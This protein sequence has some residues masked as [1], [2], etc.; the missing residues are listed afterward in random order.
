MHVRALAVLALFGALLAPHAVASDLDVGGEVAAEVAIGSPTLITLSGASGKPALLLLDVSPGPTTV[1]G[2][3]VALGFTPFTTIVAQ[4]LTDLGGS[5]AIPAVVPDDPALAGATA[6]L[7]GVLLDDA[8]PNGKDFSNGASLTVTLPVGAGAT[9]S[10]LVDRP[11]VLDGSGSTNALGNLPT[12]T[13]LLWEMIA[14]PP[15]S[16]PSLQ[17]ASTLYPILTPDLPGDY[18]IR[19]TLTG[20]LA[21]YTAETTVHAFELSL[22][23]LADGS[24]VSGASTFV[25]GGISG[26]GLASAS[27]NGV[28]LALD[29]NGNFGPVSEALPAGGVHHGLLFEMVH[30]DGTLTRER[31]T[32]QQG[33]PGFLFLPSVETLSAQIEATDLDEIAVNAEAILATSDLEGVL[34]ALPPQ[35]VAN[36]EG[37][38]GIT[39]FSATIDFTG[40]SHG[41]IDL[42]M[43]PSAGGIIGNVTIQDVRA[44]FNVFGEIVEVDYNLDGYITTDPTVIS[45]TL[46]GSASG[47]QIDVAVTNIVVD[48]QNFDFELTGFV[49]TVAELFVI[50]DSVKQDVENTI[51]GFVADDLG[52][53]VEELLN[54]F[55]IAGNL[56]ETLDVDVDVAA[57]I[58]GVVHSNHG[59]SVRLNGQAG[60]GS[61]E[62][63]APFINSYRA[64]PTPAPV[65]GSLTPGGQPY[66]SALSLA[67]DFV[68]QVLAASTGAGLLDG[69]LT[70]LIP[71]KGKV[72]VSLV[73]DEL[74]QLFPGGGFD[75]FPEGVEA[76]LDAH[77]T[78]PLVLEITP[79]GAGQGRLIMSNLEVE[80]LVPTPAG[81]LPLLRVAVDG[82]A[83]VDM[84]IGPDLTLS[85]EVVGSS[86]TFTALR[87]FP[88]A[89]PAVID[90]NVG[91]LEVVLNFAI[92]EIVAALGGIPLPSLEAQ[93]L[94]LIPSEVGVV[95]DHIVFWGDLQTDDGP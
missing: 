27:L 93:G 42:D 52:P 20:T 17:L 1:F 63:G 90:V 3:S 41:A 26:P 56:F 76:L 14:S 34:L 61:S 50:E 19:A 24:F 92:P 29:G 66:G 53:A 40:M 31:R 2:E 77:G 69:D 55:V 11:V 86:L 18:V 25:S 62:P 8:D 47:G 13:S 57:P 32:L 54:G 64:T 43:S 21:S 5:F 68:N 60:V 33:N 38:F 39:L 87:P 85:A 88:G 48:R 79:G 58:T 45:A 70:S 49:G 82:T 59:V 12:G 91:F 78:V 65:F 89:D 30:T 83:D 23:G 81:D 15:G 71:S 4:G 74:A 37:P 22:T 75:K 84:G 16:S 73:V 6:Y 44:D 35:Q 10:T 36:T 51:A 7:V 94:G 80:F 46:V 67:D 28:A 9:Q 72:P 95:G